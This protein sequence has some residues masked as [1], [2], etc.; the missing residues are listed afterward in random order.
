[1]QQHKFS[2]EFIGRKNPKSLIVF[3]HGIGG[4]AKRDYWGMLPD[5]LRYDTKCLSTDVDFWAYQSS[6]LPRLTL[7][8]GIG[9]RGRAEAALD[10]VSSLLLSDIKARAAAREYERI[11]IFG[12]SLGGLIAVRTAAS[13]L[14]SEDR[15]ITFQIDRLAI[16]ATPTT[17]VP[18]ARIAAAFTFGTNDFVT[19]LSSPT[20]LNGVFECDLSTLQQSETPTHCTY[21]H[22]SDDEVVRHGNSVSFDEEETIE[23]SHTWMRKIETPKSLNYSKLVRWI[24]S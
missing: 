20:C 23:G 8:T 24:D 13:A 1:M 22:S 15:A 2:N 19:L 21:F 9:K 18:A 12:H 10:A 5:L 4:T 14:S 11:R 16:S 7:P 6:L 3:A 17:V